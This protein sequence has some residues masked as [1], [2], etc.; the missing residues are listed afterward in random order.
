MKLITPEEVEDATV[1]RN[2]KETDIAAPTDT[3]MVIVDV[4]SK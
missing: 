4:E 3:V 2:A 1:L